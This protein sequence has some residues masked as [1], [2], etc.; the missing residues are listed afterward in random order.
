VGAPPPEAGAVSVVLTDAARTALA[1]VRAARHGALTLVIGNGCCDSTAPFLF[2]S[3][4]GGP[5]ETRIGELAGSIEVLLDSQLM[6]PFAGR[7]VVI[8]AIA[9]PGGDS[10]SAESDLGLR[11]TLERMPALDGATPALSPRTPP[12]RAAPRARS[13]R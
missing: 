13:R 4:L 5:A 12:P 2:E 6:A 1:R 10:F 9:D 8:D 3:Y 11:L 7:E